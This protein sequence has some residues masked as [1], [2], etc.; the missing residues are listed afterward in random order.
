MKKFSVI[1]FLGLSLMNGEINAQTWQ[2]LIN[3]GLDIGGRIQQDVES[4]RERERERERME[5]ERERQEREMQIERERMEAQRAAERE[6]MALERERLKQEMEQEKLRI[7]AEIE[8]EK[9]QFEAEMQAENATMINEYNSTQKILSTN[10]RKIYFLCKDASKLYISLADD[11]T[12]LF[13]KEKEINRTFLCNNVQIEVKYS[14][15][16]TVYS[17]EDSCHILLD[18]SSGYV[19]LS[20]LFLKIPSTNNIES[21]NISFKDVKVE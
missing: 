18:F 20:D 15:D 1:L 2:D 6:R 17:I 5:R 12:L 21:I 19:S 7:Q 8:K 3:V 16:N 10:N 9:A 4:R 13:E 11:N 14:G